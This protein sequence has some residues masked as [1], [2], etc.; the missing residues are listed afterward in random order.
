MDLKNSFVHSK[1]MRE[2]IFVCKKVVKTKNHFFHAYEPR[3]GIFEI[4]P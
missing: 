1:C 2:L 3:E 4:S